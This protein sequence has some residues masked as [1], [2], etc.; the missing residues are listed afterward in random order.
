MHSFVCQKVLFDLHVQSV[1]LEVQQLV[2]LITLEVMCQNR[3]CRKWRAFRLRFGAETQPFWHTRYVLKLNLKTVN[4][5]LKHRQKGRKLNCGNIKQYSCRLLQKLELLVHHLKT[6]TSLSS[7][8]SYVP[9]SKY[10]CCTVHISYSEWWCSKFWHY[11][12]VN[13][14]GD[15]TATS[16]VGNTETSWLK[17]WCFSEITVS[18]SNTTIHPCWINCFDV[19][20]E[21]TLMLIFVASLMAYY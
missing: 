12:E 4:Q 9:Y 15:N 16:C 19:K 5:D 3:G 1:C 17:L 10:C 2:R 13:I 8:W 7:L 18:I 14:C 6:D 11:H 20:I 21:F